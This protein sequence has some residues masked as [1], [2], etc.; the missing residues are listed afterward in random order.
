MTGVHYGLSLAEPHTH[1]FGVEVHTVAG[2]EPAELVMPSW[3]PGSYLLREFPRNVQQFRAEDGHGRPLA[4]SKTD[5]NRWR[6]QAVEGEAVRVR[7][8]VYANELSVRT[9]HLDASHGYVN[10]ASV[11]MYVA[12]REHAPLTL[13]IAPPPGWRATTALAEGNG[14]HTF[15]ASGYD[16]L[17]DSPIEIGTHELLEWEVDGIPHRFA[18][19]GRGN[20]DPDRLVR[21]TSR[22]IRAQKT[23][24]GG[25]PYR[26]Y[27]FFLHLLPGGYG[28][29]EHRDS[30]SLVA[31]R[32]AFG[33]REYERFLGLVAHEF[34]HLWNGKRIRPAPLGPFDYTRENY[35]RNLWVVEGLTTYYTD[36]LL[37][38]SGLI[39]PERYLERLGEAITR[40]Q[41]LPGRRVQTLEESSFDAWI[42]FYRPDAH[43]PNAQISYYQK[44][45]LI[46]LLLDLRIREATGNRRSLDDVMRL[47][48]EC[49]GERDTGFPESGPGGFE[50][51]A[52][53]IASEPLGEF[54]DA[55]LRGTDELP[56]DRFLAAAG[57]R[58]ATE[59]DEAEPAPATSVA[60]PASPAGKDAPQGMRIREE[61]GRAIVTHVL[62]GSAAHRAGVNAGDE[63]VALD[64]LRATTRALAARF[65]EREAGERIGL[66]VFRRDELLT[67]EMEVQP[68]PKPLRLVRI[69]SPSEFQESVYGDWLGIGREPD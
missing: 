17:V 66:T 59:E 8:S 6:I 67:M 45:A 21:D 32:W 57:L 63:L 7:Y 47:L 19:W 54:F 31:D 48:W 61:A 4:W 26:R 69:P 55:F 68:A 36:L 18:I 22:I 42:K 33:G 24:W 11:F 41:A 28:G 10:G 1:L 2:K 64:G 46:G 15:H 65:A 34:F 25:L 20:Y 43:T 39:T 16:E 27:T 53:E 12:G 51:L 49:Y 58:L 44:G 37:R 62:A 5:K 40:F 29:L 52:E 23:F 38:R 50:A 3:T 13:E 35:T 14:P 30:C 56:Y 60:E 9:S